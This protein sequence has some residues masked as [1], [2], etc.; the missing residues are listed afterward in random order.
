MV[1]LRKKGLSEAVS[2]WGIVYFTQKYF[3]KSQPLLPS[4]INTNIYNV[5]AC[6]YTHTYIY[7]H[8]PN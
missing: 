7:T 8:P 6:I 2:I 5:C 3:K 1:V 4:K